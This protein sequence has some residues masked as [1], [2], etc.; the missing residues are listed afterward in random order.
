MIDTREELT[1]ALHEAA[2][3]EH[4]LMI[5]YLFPAF[6]MKKRLD[7]GLSAPQQRSAR[8]WQATILRV[9]VEEMGHLGTVCNLLASIG[10]GPYLDRPNF[11]QRSGYYP[12][13]FD[14]V[15]FSDEAL[16]RM[17]VFE[18][19]QGEPLPPPPR[20]PAPDRLTMD[21]VAALSA[22][23]DPLTYDYVG[24]L[25]GDI[26]DGLRRMDEQELFIGP[27]SAQVDNSWSVDLDLRQVV[28]RSSALAAIEDIVVDGE[29]SPTERSSSHYG[30][31]ARVRQEY[32]ESGFF[33]AARPV[34]VNPRTRAQRDAPTGGTL[35][36]EER[37][38]RAAEL[39]N[40]AYGTVLLMLEQFFGSTSETPEQRAVL[41]AATSR[42][43]SVAIRPLAEVLTEL[44]AIGPGSP[45][46]AGAPFEIYDRESASPFASARWTILLERLQAVID[47]AVSLGADIPR[48]G[49][50]GDT[51]RYVRRSLAE[52]A[53]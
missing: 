23:P 43:M 14:L 41:R 27:R 28:D 11:P 39:F 46:T 47:D 12:F 50:V 8:T 26:A 6:S 42:M 16:Y 38:R 34:V 20:M 30:R 17:L 51:I 7:E 10:E 15:P 45:A 35:L 22:A 21:S 4:G 33:A 5:Q 1:V 36:V 32:E 24:E 29:G 53:A 40:G 52:V 18:L 48:V 13:P 9:A 49:A 37:T 2:E 19:P 44:P 25:Y 3:L 31:F